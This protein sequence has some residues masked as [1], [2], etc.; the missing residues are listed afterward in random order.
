MVEYFWSRIP[1]RFVD[2]TTGEPQAGTWCGNTREWYETLV[3]VIYDVSNIL[4]RQGVSSE[5][6]KRLEIQTG[7][8]IADMVRSSVFHGT[9]AGEGV[10]LVPTLRPNIQEIKF[11]DP[12]TDGWHA[13]VHV[14]DL[15]S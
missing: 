13:V 7:D 10:M 11:I 6:V 4:L 1:G 9:R 12:Q 14:L 8:S 3:E 2:K 15:T 5:V